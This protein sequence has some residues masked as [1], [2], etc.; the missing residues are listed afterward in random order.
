MNTID[1]WLKTAPIRMRTVSLILIN[2]NHDWVKQADT[3][4]GKR[5]LL[6][7]FISEGEFGTLLMSWHGKWKT[8]VRKVVTQEQ[9]DA[10]ADA[11][12]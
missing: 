9:M 3:V 12:A 11:L 2:E 10:L 6:N 7:L 5:S 8:D 4:D 1:E